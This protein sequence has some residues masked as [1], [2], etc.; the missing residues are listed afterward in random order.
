M[1]LKVLNVA[2]HHCLNSQFVGMATSLMLGWQS[3]VNLA[4]S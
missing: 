1:H 4:Y 2:H 3:S